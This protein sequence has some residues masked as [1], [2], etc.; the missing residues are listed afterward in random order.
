M[1][2]IYKNLNI[3][4]FNKFALVIYHPINEMSYITFENILNC[5]KE[6]NMNAFVSYPNIDLGNKEIIRVIE[7][8][9]NN[10]NFYFYKN[11]YL[12]LKF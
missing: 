2:T 1:E 10:S 12:S 3:K 4:S 9:K 6:I 8:Y 11:I 7:K 5:L